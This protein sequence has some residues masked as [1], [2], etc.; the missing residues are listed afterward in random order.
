MD[1][2]HFSLQGICLLS[3]ILIIPVL[4]DT[5]GN[6]KDIEAVVQEAAEDF[7]SQDYRFIE[8]FSPHSCQRLKALLHLSTRALALCNLRLLRQAMHLLGTKQPTRRIFT[9]HSLC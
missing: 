8:N 6:E 4:E 7:Y 9:P 5:E 1:W 3:W 2:I